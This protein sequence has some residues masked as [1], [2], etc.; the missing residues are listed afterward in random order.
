MKAYLD[1]N[2][3]V[4]IE[5]GKYRLEDFLSL[6]NTVYYYSDVHMNELLEAKGNPKV[7]QEERLELITKLCGQNYICSGAIKE[8]EFLVKDCRE[9]YKLADNPL[10]VLINRVVSNSV[11]VFDKIREIIGFDSRS[12]NNVQSGCVLQMIDERMREKLGMGLLEYLF[13]TEAYG[14]ALYGTLMNIVDMANY[15]KDNQT[16]HSDV[17]RLC[18]ASHAY[19]AQICDVL[20]TG[21]RKMRAKVKAVYSFLGVK[22]KVVSVDEFFKVYAV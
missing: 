7:P 5:V 13:R 14:R 22:T 16:E 1:N 21:D 8:P 17:A 12:F 9:I 20:V 19:S 6:A 4:D 11:E 15:W 18:D 10:R 2:V 3:L